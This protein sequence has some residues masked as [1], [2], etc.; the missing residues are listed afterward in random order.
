MNDIIKPYKQLEEIEQTK[1]VKQIKGQTREPLYQNLKSHFL[2]LT[3]IGRVIGYDELYEE[4]K[5][6]M[7]LIELQK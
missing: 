2:E 4:L 6:A 3:S 7:H 5:K 1:E